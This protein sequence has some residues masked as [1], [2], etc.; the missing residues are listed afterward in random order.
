ME[1]K[2]KVPPEN[3]AGTAVQGCGVIHI[4][5]IQ[6]TLTKLSNDLEFPFDLNDYTLGSTG[7]KEYS[8]DID[9]VLD[10][11][12]WVYGSKALKE[13]LDG[14]FGK[15]NVKIQ[16][17]MVH[18]KYP[19]VNYNEKQDKRKPRTGFVQIDFNFGDTEWE[20][21]YHY[22]PGSE[23]AYKGAHRNLALAAITFAVNKTDADEKDSYDRPVWEIR[24]KWSPKGFVKVRRVSLKDSRTGNWM[25]KR[26]DVVIE[27]PHF[28][29]EQIARILFPKD[30]VISD[31]N[32]LETIISAVKRNYSLDEQELIWQRMA[33]NFRD[34]RDG[35]DFVYP[36]EI[37]RYFSINDK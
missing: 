31:L 29:P 13:D 5:E 27:G 30:G 25:K 22:S 19:I 4:H 23:S 1:L 18:L 24:W 20:K 3:E 7:K 15:E 12:W 34:W 33:S 17:S 9:L 6:P 21:F 37:D 28:S 35:K 11:K 16:G 26:E 36:S 2:Y 10:N 32:S 14:I 8:G